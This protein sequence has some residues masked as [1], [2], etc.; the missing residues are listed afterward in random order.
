MFALRLRSHFSL[1]HGTNSPENICRRAKELGYLGLALTDKNNLYGLPEFVKACRE[2]GLIPLIGAELTDPHSKE[3]ISCLVTSETG[4]ANLC[5]LITKRHTEEDF[6]LQ[7]IPAHLGKGLLLFCSTSRQ[8]HH[9]HRQ[10]FTVAADLGP[11][12]N[13]AATEVKRTADQYAI[14]TVF[15]TDASLLF[16]Q[17]RDLHH[18]LHVIE[19]N[20]RLSSIDNKHANLLLAPA[21]YRNNFSL[22][23]EVIRNT[24]KLARSISYHGPSTGL[25]M[26]PWKGTGNVDHVLR[27]QAYKGAVHRYGADL[28][29][30][31]VERLEY[32]LKI[33][34]EMNF[35]SYFLVVRDIVHRKGK[36]GSRKKRRIC[37]RGSGAASLVAYCLEITNI[38]PIK[39]NLYFE[40]F[41]NP[42]RQDPPDI[43]ID[44]AWDERDKVLDEILSDYRGHVA[45]VCNHV[46]FK[47]RMAIRE[48]AKAFGLTAYEIS[49]LTKRIP[50]HYK[51]EKQSLLETIKLTSSLKDQDL[52]EPWPQIFQLAEQLIGLPRYLSVH[53]G[54]VVITPAKID[55]HVPLEKAPKGVSI[56]QWEKDGAEDMGLIKIDIL[57][58]RSL[59]VI[60]DCIANIRENGIAFDELLWEPEDDPATCEAVAR[61]KTMGCFYIESPAMRLL[62]KKAG[63][64]NFEQLVLQSSIIRPAANDFVREYVRRLHGGNWDH[65]HPRLADVLDET[66]GLMVYQ[67]DV[68]K[69]AVTL[70]GFSHA[71]ADGLRKVLSKKDREVRLKDYKED[72]YQGCKKNNIT[73]EIIDQLWQ[74]MMSFDGYSFCKPHSASYA[75]VSF[76]AAYL[77]THFPAEF[78]AAVISNQGGF[79]STFAYVS[80]AKRMGIDVLPPDINHSQFKWLGKRDQ[81]R[82]GFLSIHSLSLRCIRRLLSERARQPF[83]SFYD[84]LHRVR[85]AE[86]EAKA[87]LHTGSIDSISPHTSRTT[88]LWQLAQFKE[89][90]S[91]SRT[92]SLFRPRQVAA[93]SLPDQ[94]AAMRYRFEYKNLG[95]LCSRHPITFFAEQTASMVKGAAMHQHINRQITFAGWLLT[96]KI[97]STKTGEAMEFLTF[98]DET[99]TVETTFFPKIYHR[100]SHLLSTGKPYILEGLVEED[101]NA[102]T[103]TVQRVYPLRPVPDQGKKCNSTRR[104]I[105]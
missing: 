42:G 20:A 90:Q 21:V 28:S 96:G 61:G 37:G 39:N 76:Q 15:T 99:A 48:T 100:Y 63:T 86:D 57:G 87:L 74:M 9:F 10:N 84:F 24:E 52:T 51:P 62:Q 55:S 104:F 47:P 49:Q 35:S 65:L 56:M 23:P 69:V 77:K 64:G 43:D 31:V 101:F 18:L 27:E 82:P 46:Y 91:R 72:F 8:L 50:Y 22:W 11:R 32:E 67:E 71:R 14:P 26:P 5:R 3:S 34:Q 6:A 1:Y 73:S 83:S 97:V 60:R 75:R 89:E 80:E 54:G 79:Y 36:D 41:L 33:I 44:F 98:E 25:I 68:S 103:L 30:A 58:N 4:Y 13:G 29:E 102:L 81:L 85:P 78:M 2:T 88:L 12:P 93:P 95:F 7:S 92:T 19:K 59:G 16:Q 105:A 66:F 53:P 38:C 17:E 45:M 40:R 70:A 94:P